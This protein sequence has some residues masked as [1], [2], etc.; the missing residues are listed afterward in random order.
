MF[1]L[2]SGLPPAVIAGLALAG[3]A[4]QLPQGPAAP[5]S[6]LHRTGDEIVVCGQFFHTGTPV[7]LWM[8]PG[9]YD[10]YRPY[11]SSNPEETLPSKPAPGCKTPARYDPIRDNLDESTAR[12][13]RERGWDVATLARAVDLFV[14]HY[15]AGGVS[16]ECFRVLHDERG[17]SVHF[18]L[19]LDGTIYQTLDLKERARHAGSVNGR[20]IGIEI[21]N[22]GAHE[23]ADEAS[24]WYTVDD[25]GQVR[26]AI[27]PVLGDGGI[28]T[29]NFVARPARPGL[30]E[31]TIQ[32]RRLHQY[33]FTDA[34]YEALIKL[35][36]A[37]CR[38]LTRIRVD[39]PRDRHDQL[40]TELLRPD[41]LADFSG[42]LGHF[43]V[44]AA[45][46]D[47]G[48]AFD[49]DRLLA[50]VRAVK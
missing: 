9:G 22:I 20:S 37:L 8:D 5:G 7:V 3:C 25:D 15:D 35:T 43:H 14:I 48:P 28:R 6:R 24:D 47:P 23:D 29:P 33:D 36:A 34:Q 41:E 1:V 13:V 40:R 39:Y 49:W 16:R 4:R 10:A 31:G 30:I 19:D 32:N 12:S 38:V 11:R 26:V 27:P 21:A 44:S 2:R 18:L 42:L 17:L 46:V 50:G 45:K